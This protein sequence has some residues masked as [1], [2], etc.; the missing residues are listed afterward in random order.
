MAAR[1]AFE[2]TL[3]VIA[4]AAWRGGCYRSFRPRTRAFLRPRAVNSATDLSA[5]DPGLLPWRH[6]V[7]IHERLGCVRRPCGAFQ[8]CFAAAS[9]QLRRLDGISRRPLLGGGT[10]ARGE[11]GGAFGFSMGRQFQRPGKKF[12]NNNGLMAASLRL[13]SPCRA[14]QFYR[15]DRG[16]RRR[17]ARSDARCQRGYPHRR[18]GVHAS[19]SSGAYFGAG[20]RYR[21]AHGLE[22]ARWLDGDGKPFDILAALA[23]AGNAGVL[24]RPI[25]VARKKAPPLA[26]R[27]VAFRKP[28][29]A[30][31][32]RGRKRGRPQSAKATPYPAA[33]WPPPHGLFLLPRSMQ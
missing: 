32:A 19:R 27:L 1:I 31:E 7:K 17:A 26:L 8:C 23:A 5:A 24:D 18:S 30:A 28:P 15:V 2:R 10:S 16:E 14:L 22:G 4:E 21:R 6:G 25:W 13:R 12:K 11:T 20:R 33:R 3:A 29:Q 9:A